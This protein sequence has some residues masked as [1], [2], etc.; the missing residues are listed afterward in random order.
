MH[1][2]ILKTGTKWY[3]S[4]GKPANLLPFTVYQTSAGRSAVTNSPYFPQNT[5]NMKN[6]YTK[7]TF[8]NF[9][10][11]QYAW[12]NANLEHEYQKNPENFRE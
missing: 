9:T 5:K 2:A 11:L 12:K 3:F 6:F 8:H 10:L 7:S 4:L 1:D